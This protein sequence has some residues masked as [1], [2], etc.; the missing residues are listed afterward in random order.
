MLM[1]GN[2]QEGN[3]ILFVFY[4][5]DMMENVISV[6]I[7]SFSSS[8]KFLEAGFAVEEILVGSLNFLFVKN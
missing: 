1:N 6:R 4:I 8:I 7:K 5:E 2:L 3:S